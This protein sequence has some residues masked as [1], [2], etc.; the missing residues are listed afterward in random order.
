MDVGDIKQVL[1]QLI[2]VFEQTEPTDKVKIYNE[3]MTVVNMYLAEV[4]T[5]IGFGGSDYADPQKVMTTHLL[6]LED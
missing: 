6:L 2:E 4:A 3:F 5:E 1:I